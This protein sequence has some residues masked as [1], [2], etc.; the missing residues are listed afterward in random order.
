MDT[1]RD[2]ESGRESYGTTFT[3][4]SINNNPGDPRGYVSAVSIGLV[5]I[6]GRE[7]VGVLEIGGRLDFLDE[8]F[9]AEEGSELRPQHFDRH[10]AAV[11][12]GFGG[13]DRCHAA[14]A[15]FF[16]D[17]IA[18]GEGGLEAVHKVWHCVLAPLASVLEYG[19][20]S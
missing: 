13:V 2:R 12:Q 4:W 15:E 20:G 5:R 16:L 3:T 10:L 14:R 6:E 9:G 19:P 18:V 11:L 7:D 8:P 17:G 1:P